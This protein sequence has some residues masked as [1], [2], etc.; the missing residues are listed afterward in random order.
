MPRAPFVRKPAAH[1][2]AACPARAGFYDRFT[3]AGHKLGAS[4]PGYC[5]GGAL[6]GANV[7]T[8]PFHFR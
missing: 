5:D 3:Q 2:D 1:P 7:S 8:W 4:T 6:P